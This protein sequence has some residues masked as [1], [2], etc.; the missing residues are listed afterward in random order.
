MATEAQRRANAKYRAAN[1]ERCRETARLANRRRYQNDERY[2]QHCIQ[3][4]AF[5]QTSAAEAVKNILKEQNDNSIN[6]GA[7]S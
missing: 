2:R 3:K 5:R 7:D 6:N 1:L 4:A